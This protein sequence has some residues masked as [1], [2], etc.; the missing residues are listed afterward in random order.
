MITTE[1]SSSVNLKLR[2]QVIIAGSTFTAAGVLTLLRTMGVITVN[3][4]GFTTQGVVKGK[5]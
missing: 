5:Y 1:L 3:L 4:L 2:V